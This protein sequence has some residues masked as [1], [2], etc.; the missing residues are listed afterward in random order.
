MKGYPFSLEGKVVLI[1]GASSGIG[2]ST[3][4]HVASLGG[5]CILSGRDKDRLNETHKDLEGEGHLS[6]QGDLSCKDF[7]SEMIR[8]AVKEIGAI[9]GFVHCAGL[10]RTLPF[11]STTLEDLHSIMSVNLDV[12]WLICQ[13][14]LK[15]G[16]HEKDLSIVGIGSMAGQ[17]GAPGK[18]AYSASKGA[19]ISLI[20]TL[21]IEYAPKGIRFN[22]VCPGYV[23]TP[24]LDRMKSLYPS[25]EAFFSSM[26]QLHPLGLGKPEDVANAII[27]LLGSASRW[28]TG[29]VVDVDGGYGCV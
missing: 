20:R 25:E 12:F 4:I 18:T 26:G 6:L 27:F 9:S 5:K 28:M 7:L 2:R 14:I 15:R 13:E 11:R 10:E 8:S 3:A 19:L 16:S 22:C 24:M 17:F 21:A 1:T 29:S 23:E